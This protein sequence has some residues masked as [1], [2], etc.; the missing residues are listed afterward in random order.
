MSKPPMAKGPTR[1]RSQGKAKMASGVNKPVKDE[2]PKPKKAE[3]TYSRP[4]QTG[5]R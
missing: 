1:E 5:K 4:S 3:V 2:M